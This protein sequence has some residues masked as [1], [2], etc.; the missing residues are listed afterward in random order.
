MSIIRTACL[1]LATCISFGVLSG[2]GGEEEG[3]LTVQVSG[4]VTY[5]G[6]PLPEGRIVLRPAEGEGRGYSGRIEDGSFSFETEPGNK[7]VEITASREVEVDP[8]EV[9]PEE[10]VQ[11]EEEGGTVPEQY[12]P[13][14]YNKETTLTAEVTEGGDNSFSFELESGE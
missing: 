8:S 3:P 12:I 2:C 9:S 1:F 6:E 13:A 5:D 10:Q 14:Q 11:L 4:T 7:K